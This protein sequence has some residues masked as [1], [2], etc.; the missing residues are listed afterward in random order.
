MQQK[1]LDVSH[2]TL[3]PPEANGIP[4]RRRSVGNPTKIARPNTLVFMAALTS[5]HVWKKEMRAVA[6]VLPMIVTQLLAP[7]MSV[8]FKTH[9]MPTRIAMATAKRNGFQISMN[10][11]A[12]ATTTGSEILATNMS[13]VMT[14]RIAVATARLQAIRP[15]ENAIALVLVTSQKMIKY[16]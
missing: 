3:T 14:K 4:K 5:S 12:I 8:W 6:S 1:G 10:A 2:T 11:A 16:G 9:V 15:R 13:D 7:T